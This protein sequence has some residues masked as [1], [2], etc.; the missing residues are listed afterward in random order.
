MNGKLDVITAGKIYDILV[1]EC[2]A[3]AKD[4]YS[5]VSG[6]GEGWALV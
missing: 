2:G 5:F 3:W 1:Q 6:Q 4:K